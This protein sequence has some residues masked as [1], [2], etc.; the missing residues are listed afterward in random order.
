MLVSEMC[1]SPHLFG[2]SLNC[3]DVWLIS[4]TENQLQ[5]LQKKKAKL[6]CEYIFSETLHIL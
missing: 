1:Y 6:N 5:R 4:N 3:T 2:S